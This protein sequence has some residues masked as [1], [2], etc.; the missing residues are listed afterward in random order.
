MSDTRSPRYE[1]SQLDQIMAGIGDGVVDAKE[2]AEEHLPE[3]AFVG[4]SGAFFDSVR[5]IRLLVPDHPR[6]RR[7][8]QRLKK[9]TQAGEEVLVCYPYESC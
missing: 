9:P 5:R 1:A 2:Q 6:V 7:Q 8:A 4:D 3:E